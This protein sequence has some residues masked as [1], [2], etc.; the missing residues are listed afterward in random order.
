MRIVVGTGTPTITS[1]TDNNIY[2]L[3]IARGSITYN[4]TTA[5]TIKLTAQVDKDQ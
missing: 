3:I 4:S 1:G 5:L 2:A